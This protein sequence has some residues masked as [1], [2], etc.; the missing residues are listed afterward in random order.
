MLIV[1]YGDDTFLSRRY[2]NEV[3]NFYFKTNP[4]YFSYDF[5]EKNI[6]NN[7]NED[8]DILKSIFNE[9]NLFSSTKVILLENIFSYAPKSF[10]EE[11]IRLFKE[12]KIFKAKDILVIIFEDNSKVNLNF[13]KDKAKIFK[14]FSF[15]KGKEL[16]D[17]IKEEAKSFG[18][19]L[20]SE[21]LNILEANFKDDTAFIYFALK[22][23]S[24]LDKSLITKNDV[25]NNI[26]LENNSNIFNLLDAL[27]NKKIA[28]AFKY[29]E[30]EMESGSVGLILWQII[31][32]IKTLIILNQTSDKNIYIVSK[33]FNIH[34]YVAK[35]L[36]LL[37]KKYNF[38]KLLSIYQKLSNYDLK[39][40]SGKIDPGLALNLIVLDFSKV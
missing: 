38:T 37:S 3:R 25:L 5:K 18:I 6:K 24:Q 35:K 40:K 14:D 4:F 17:F 29:L 26:Y 21:A 20:D 36:F 34:P 16:T 32:E 30:K 10:Q 13:F 12:N 28:L 8:L 19:Q 27:V 11:I 2:L 31:K 39:I 9:R 1:I 23:L 15:K 33:K 22:K 7:I